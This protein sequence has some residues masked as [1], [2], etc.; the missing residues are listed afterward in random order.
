MDP[1]LNRRQC[2]AERKK[3]PPP[4]FD[5]PEVDREVME[6]VRPTDRGFVQDAGESVDTAATGD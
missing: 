5:H 6:E 4:N 1:D 2:N 3:D